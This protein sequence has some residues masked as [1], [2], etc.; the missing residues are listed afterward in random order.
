MAWRL[1]MRLD[2][3]QLKSE[4]LNRGTDDDRPSLRFKAEV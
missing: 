4:T 1:L 2:G 3:R